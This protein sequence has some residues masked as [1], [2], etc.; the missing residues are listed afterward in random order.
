MNDLKTP[1]PVLFELTTVGEAYVELHAE[2]STLP[3]AATFAR[4]LAGSAA[5]TAIY[6]S[7]FGGKT[8]CVACVGAD[9]L[10]TFVQNTLREH[11]VESASIQFSRDHPTSLRF[12]S[13]KGR[14]E[15]TTYYRLADW[16]LHNTKEHVAQAQSSRIV[17]GSG[18]I[19][20]KHPA[21]HSLFEMLRLSKKWSSTT[22]FQPYCEPSHGPSRAE[23][24]ATIKKTLQFADILTPRL[25]DA[26]ALFGKGTKE[27][28]L[29]QYHDMGAQTVI[30]N[31]GKQGALLSDG[32][33]V[34]RV[35]GVEG[36]TVD[37][38]GVDEAWHAALFY[39]MNKQKAA[40]NAV[41]FANTVAAYVL[42][43]QGSIIALPAPGEITQEMLGK[44]FE[45][46]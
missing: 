15:Q 46:V 17:F 20:L 25:E 6:Y 45:D 8:N 44:A 1:P 12:S 33:K 36:E 38:A 7:M 32:V 5:L 28:F 42:A 18:F 19:L 16:Q 35:P 40:P 24:Q 14:L 3:E 29:K 11:K 37:T 4:R 10:G 39:A 30:M 27:D 34:V 21:R 2:D 9:A 43:R 41:Y 22:V 31:L 13:K 23:M 26:E